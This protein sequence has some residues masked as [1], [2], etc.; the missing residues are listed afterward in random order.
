MRRVKLSVRADRELSRIL[1]WT[2]AHWGRAQ[3]E[4]Y[5]LLL[6][7]RMFLLASEPELGRPFGPERPGLMQAR[8]GEHLIFYRVQPHELIVVSVMHGR[9]NHG[10]RLGSLTGRR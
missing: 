9:Q 1:Q 10:R 6:A 5:D 8:A 4:R 2:E 7:D 3:R